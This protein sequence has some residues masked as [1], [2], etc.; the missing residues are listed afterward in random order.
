MAAAPSV[1]GRF[2]SSGAVSIE[3]SR[4]SGGS[5]RPTRFTS[6]SNVEPDG[7]FS[8]VALVQAACSRRLLGLLADPWPDDDIDARVEPMLAKD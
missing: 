7:S 4:C 6:A 3:V 8:I 1:V 5:P 2:G